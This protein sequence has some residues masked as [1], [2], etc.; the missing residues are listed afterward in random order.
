MSN[1]RRSLTLI[2]AVLVAAG[3]L[4]H[5]YTTLVAAAGPVEAFHLGLLAW[6][7]L[8]YL[9]AALLPRF[10]AAPSTAAGFALGALL[11][12]LYMHY[13]VFIAPKGSTAALGLLFMPL[14]N[15]LVLGPLGALAVRAGVR[16]LGRPDATP[17][18]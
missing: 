6:S 3:V 12:D 18:P 2:P 16:L 7:C 5:A 13:A 17:G 8:P 11:G 15:F 14:W 9:V 10:G 4:L 1:A